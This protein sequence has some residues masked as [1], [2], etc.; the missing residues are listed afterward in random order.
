MNATGRKRA[1][2]R[3]KRTQAAGR[4]AAGRPK[5]RGKGAKRA[6]RPIWQTA[7]TALGVLAVLLVAAAGL[8]L[9]W[10]ALSGP[11]EG[12]TVV[13][14]WPGRVGPVEAAAVLHQHGLIESPRWFSTYFRLVG[15]CEACE[16]GTHLLRD[17]LSP[18]A[19]LAWLSRGET[20]RPKVKVPIPEGWN[21]LQ[22]AQ[23]LS[24]KSVCSGDDF[25][26]ISRS[27]RL[28]DEF[29][30]RGES[31]EGYLFPATYDLRL[32][33]S[34]DEVVRRM[35]AETR[36]RLRRLLQKHPDALGKLMP[37]RP[38]A[39]RELVILA[40][41]VE[42]E[43]RHDDERATIASVYYNRLTS[44]EF[45]PAHRLQADPT[46]AYGCTIEAKKAPSCGGFTGRVTPAMLRDDANRY[47]T[48][49]HGG[50]PPGPIC[51]PGEASLEAVLVPADTDYLYFV[52]RPDGRHTFS[53]TY[54]QHNRAIRKSDG[55]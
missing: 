24:Q 50:L 27:R 39:E 41:I 30:I 42:K 2:R 23:R 44:P 25:L 51:N 26:R 34:P 4:T 49:R 53:H 7:G 52:A 21:S 8:L 46:A 29:G 14:K 35:V 17:D 33:S 54:E 32:N 3:K 11:G 18:R 31:V 1:H 6:R 37:G 47:N 48:Y 38:W 22:V 16:P 43:A 9:G 13:V 20:G 10:A 15:G 19:L 5:K 36:A 28:L 55:R 12:R 40:S 45:A